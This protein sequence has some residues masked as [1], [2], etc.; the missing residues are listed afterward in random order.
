MKS[1]VLSLTLLLFFV[2]TA[3]DDDFVERT[4][5]YAI[6]S[7]N[8]FNA[9]ADYNNAL[10]A[11][12]DLLQASYLNV[13]LG[14]IASDNTLA[15]GETATDAPGI[16]QID[17]MIHTPVNGQLKNI[18]DWMFAGVQ[19]ATF[20]IEFQDKTEF[21]GRAQIVAEARFLRAYYNFELT[22]WFGPIPLKS[23]ARF[24]LG[25]ESSIPRATVSEVYDAIESD[26][27][28]AIADLAVDAPAIGR[29]SRDAALALL[30]KAHLYQKEYAQAATAL[31][32]VIDSGRYQLADDYASIWE[33]TGENGVESVFEVQ[34]T[35]AEGATFDCFQCSEGNVAV[36]FNGIRN[37]TGP[38]YDNGFS[39]NVPTEEAFN[40]FEQG[41]SRQEVS[42]LD[43]DAWAAE[44]GAT[45][46]IGN[47]HTGYY[48]R[49]YIARKGDAN[50]GD[51][52]LT[53]P[54]NYRSIRY[55]D[56]LLMAAEAFA[57]MEMSQDGKARDYLNQVRR[58]AFG[59]MDH[60]I[61]ASGPALQ[62]FI[63]RERRLEFVGEGHRFFDLVRTGRAAGAIDGFTAGKHEVFPVPFQEIQFSNGNW[64]QNP[65]Y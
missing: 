35:D 9:E 26:L 45:F 24:A 64:E 20:I 29:V 8:Y 33:L 3:C 13:M 43:I 59:D 22:K 46:G 31:L 11:A 65:M 12:Y 21:E 41:D 28:L 36:G 32:G 10:I 1:K 56:V 4:P 17:D 51:P 54:N 15:G 50:I 6:D 16:Q 48:N 60:D 40:A 42:I 23:D 58:R 61:S 37:H 57:F 47:E 18:W 39:F 19:R 38:L 7:E 52:V 44:T 2:V 53:N 5:V 34:Y 63:L 14:E 49:K 62:D 27:T 25:D 55:A 30:G